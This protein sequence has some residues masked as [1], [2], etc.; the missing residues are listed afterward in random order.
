MQSNVISRDSYLRRNFNTLFS[1]IMRELNFVHEG[2]LEVQ[3]WFNFLLKFLKS[4]DKACILFSNKEKCTKET[5][6]PI[7]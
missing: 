5:S 3:S 4:V 2:N 1:H 6:V 7:S